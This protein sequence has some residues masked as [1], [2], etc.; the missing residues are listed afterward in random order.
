MF[1]WI[2]YDRNYDGDI[3]NEIFQNENQD[4]IFDIIGKNV[5]MKLR[6][7]EDDQ[8]IYA[9]N[10]IN[11]ILYHGLMGNLTADSRISLRGD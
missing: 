5:A 10:L 7:M 1:Q 8:R 6:D 2:N 3:K 4:D 11:E 9:E